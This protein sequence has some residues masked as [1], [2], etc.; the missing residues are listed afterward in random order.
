MKS[1][2]VPTLEDVAREA[3]VSTATVSRCLNTPERVIE[4][5]RERVMSAVDKLGYYPNF[6]ARALVAKRTNTYGTV[7][8][9][10]ENAVFA[11]GIQAF[12]EALHDNGKTLFI[13]SSSY[14]QDI[15][16]EQIRTLVARGADGLLLIGHH[17]SKGIYEFLSERDVPALI[18]W[19]YEADRPELS[20]GFDNRLAM[21]RLA[22]N[23]LEKGHR[24]IAIISAQQA[25]NDRARNRVL[26]IVDAMQEW[27][28]SAERL[29]IVETTYGVDTG[30][31]AFHSLMTGSNRPTAVMCGNDVL[32]VGALRG[33]RHLGLRVPDDISVTGFDDIELASI[34]DPELTTVHVPHRKMG[35][36]AAQMLIDMVEGNPPEKSVE[37]QTRICLRKSLAEPPKPGR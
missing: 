33:A 25:S 17:R 6:G 10:M 28:I 24:D 13:S 7:I 9:T 37:L 30:E 36:L 15:E 34:A 21:K 32:A 2:S 3:G 23:V 35:S 12:Q 31:A 20:I 16:E 22:E 26:G 4:A 14:Q 5:T 18:A 19:V 1:V 27:G 11:R 8:P 29:Q